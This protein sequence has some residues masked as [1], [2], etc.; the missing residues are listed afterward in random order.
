MARNFPPPPVAWT[1]PDGTLTNDARRFLIDLFSQL[2]G[3]QPLDIASLKAILEAEDKKLFWVA[4][5]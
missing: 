2:G 3:N 4:G 1:R 5:L